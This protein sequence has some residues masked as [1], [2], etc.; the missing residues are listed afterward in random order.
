MVSGFSGKVTNFRRK[1]T[2]NQ[3][4][5]IYVVPEN[6]AVPQKIGVKHE[7]IGKV[8]KNAVK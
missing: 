8:V 1:L 4:I 5:L 2:K 7:T 6:P 3:I